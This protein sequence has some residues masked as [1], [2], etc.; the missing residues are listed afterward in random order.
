MSKAVGKIFGGG[1]GASTSMYGGEQEILNYLNNYNTANYDTTLNNLTAYAA[2]ASNRL[3]GM[4]DYQ[5]GFAEQFVKL[6]RRQEIHRPYVLCP[7]LAFINLGNHFFI[8]VRRHFVYDSHKA[9]KGRLRPDCTEY[10]SFL[11]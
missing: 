6:I 8:Q 11:Y 7:V 5:P 1:A 4:G 10:H 3:A 9:V 2:N